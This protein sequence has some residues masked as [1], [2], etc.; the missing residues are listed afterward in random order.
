[1]KKYK[2]VKTS[3]EINERIKEGKAVV[4]T[5][6][7][8][9]DIVEKSGEIKAPVKI[10]VVT[11]GTFAPPSISYS[12]S[13]KLKCQ[14]GENIDPFAASPSQAFYMTGDLAGIDIFAGI[15]SDEQIP[16]GM[17]KII[18]SGIAIAV[19]E[20]YEAQIVPRKDLKDVRLINYPVIIDANCR[21]EIGV[22]MINGGKE[23][24][25]VK[26]G[27][28]IGQMVVYRVCGRMDIFAA[29]KGEEIS[30]PGEWKDVPTGIT[31]ALPKGY[32]AQIRPLN[33]HARKGR[34]KLRKL[35]VFPVTIDSDYRD[36]IVVTM[37]NDGRRQLTVKRG[38]HIAEM[39]I[40][41]A[42]AG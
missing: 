3:E 12:V 10:D 30:L 25:T 32:E 26:R 28:H 38:D 29:V 33:V 4:V 31:I 1:M 36:E 13:E 24:L 15:K 39:I 18:P 22:T 21:E 19:P 5:A 23:P 2:A 9:L 17:G 14:L 35:R 6:E 27:D 11:T 7:E 34:S 42:D 16:P 37:K 20:G 8:I 40:Y 41:R